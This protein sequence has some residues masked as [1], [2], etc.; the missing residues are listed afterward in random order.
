MLSKEVVRAWCKLLHW[1]LRIRLLLMMVGWLVVLL[2]LN[3]RRLLVGVVRMMVSRLGRYKVPIALVQMRLLRWILLLWL[4][5][6]E[7][8]CT[9][10]LHHRLL[11][12]RWHRLRTLG[13]SP[14][15]PVVSPAIGIIV[16]GK[17][18]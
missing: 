6:E 12:L 4:R 8:V 15:T 9:H 5:L 13:V 18:C 11:L 7:M 2:L 1:N 16:V 14:I 3:R 10:R 17:C